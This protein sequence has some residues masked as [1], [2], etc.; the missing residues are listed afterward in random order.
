[1]VEDETR[2]DRIRLDRGQNLRQ[3]PLQPAHRLRH[4]VRP[5]HKVDPGNPC[6]SKRPREPPNQP[7]IPGSQLDHLPRRKRQET[8]RDPPRIA[9]KNIQRPQI[10][11]TPNGFRVERI[12]TIKNFGDEE[13]VGHGYCK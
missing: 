10:P 12:Q 3:I 6:A 9:Q 2:H 5:G 7:S 11:P 8:S 1:M 4:P 13:A